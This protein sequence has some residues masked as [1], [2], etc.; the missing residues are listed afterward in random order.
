V[1]TIE[2]L[3]PYEAATE[4]VPRV[5][6]SPVLL[7][8][9]PRL[10]VAKRTIDVG[11]AIVLLLLLLPLFLV[12]AVAIKIDDRGPV[13]YRQHRVGFLNAPFR[14]VK[15]RSMVVDADRLR[16]SLADR[17]LNDGLLFK[18]AGDPRV[19]RFGRF[20]RR[21][22]LDELPQ[23]WNVVRGDM[24]LVGPR[25][26]PVPPEAFSASERRRHEVLPGITGLWQVSGANELNYHQMIELDLA[27][28]EQRSLAG[29][30]RI[31]LRTVPALMGRT[32]PV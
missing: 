18:V 5:V 20:I 28:V 7:V 16:A 10:S 26:L 2:Q 29:D 23:L 15:F 14:M 8:A 24:S 13:F 21:L 3:D 4:A 17:N 25:P 30:L 6:A 12:V 31:I 32:M 1:T 19:T 22:S 9:P 27:Y 11:L